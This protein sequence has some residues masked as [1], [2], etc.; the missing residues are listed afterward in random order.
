M[1]GTVLCAEEEMILRV[2]RL[3]FCL[4]HTTHSY[5]S[6]WWKRGQYGIMERAGCWSH[7]SLKRFVAAIMV[8]KC[9]ELA[10]SLTL[11]RCSPNNR[12]CYF[13]WLVFMRGFFLPI[14]ANFSSASTVVPNALSINLHP[15]S[16]SG[17]LCPSRCLQSSCCQLL[18]P[19]RNDFSC[20]FLVVVLVF[21][22]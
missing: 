21:S 15:C 20:H 17:A 19:P 7:S 13:L 16:S 4:V 6:L 8:N 18:S 1:P 11:G 14:A 3:F 2:P 12:Y 22:V 9:K 5:V 10:P